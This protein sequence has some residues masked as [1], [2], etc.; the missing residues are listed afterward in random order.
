MHHAQASNEHMLPG[1]Q[2]LHCSSVCVGLCTVYD[3]HP[4]APGTLD[5]LLVLVSAMVKII[6][7]MAMCTG[8]SIEWHI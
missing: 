5:A 4:I 7:D 8:V 2:L 1:V 6:M 3:G